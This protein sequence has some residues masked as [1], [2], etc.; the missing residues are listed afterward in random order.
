MMAHF[1]EENPCNTVTED[2]STFIDRIFVNFYKKVAKWPK[3][4]FFY[5]LKI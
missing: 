2:I 3:L 5:K 1:K 4:R